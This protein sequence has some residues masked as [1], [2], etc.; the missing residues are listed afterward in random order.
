MIIIT[1]FYKKPFELLV[2]FGKGAAAAQECWDTHGRGLVTEQLEF[3][4]GRFALY[5]LK[6]E[7]VNP[8]L[9]RIC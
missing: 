4:V 8:W 7:N 5:D 6:I 2:W 1:L 3:S 9:H